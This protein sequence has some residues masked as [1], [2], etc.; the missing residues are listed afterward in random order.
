VQASP[1]Y[2]SCVQLAEAAGVPVAEVLQEVAAAGAELIRE[3]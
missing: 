1:E 3:T 2:E